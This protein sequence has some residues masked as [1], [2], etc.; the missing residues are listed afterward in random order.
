VAC[1]PVRVSLG[2]TPGEIRSAGKRY[3]ALVRQTKGS[4]PPHALSLWDAATRRNAA[5]LKQMSDRLEVE[6]AATGLDPD[7]TLHE[8]LARLGQCASYGTLPPDE[9]A[10]NVQGGD[11]RQ[12]AFHE[13]LRSVLPSLG[14]PAARCGRNRGSRLDPAEPDL[15]RWIPRDVASGESPTGQ[16]VARAARSQN[17]EVE[18]CSTRSRNV[19]APQWMSS[20]TP[21]I[22]RSAAACSS[23]LRKAQA[24]PSP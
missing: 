4:G 20:K 9:L 1:P 23:V 10:R 15:Y 24:I 21:T 14:L 2:Q 13:N 7:G 5:L 6:V 22:A 16:A 17:V 19:S 3:V 8:M 11:L 12:G 18:T